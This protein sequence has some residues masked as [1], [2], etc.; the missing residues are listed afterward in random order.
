MDDIYKV[1]LHAPPHYFVPSAMYMVTG[2]ILHKQNL[3]RDNRCKKFFLRT[4]FEKAD[5]FR[6]HLQAWAVLHNHYHFISQSPEN[7]TT[8]AKLI[9]QVH[10]ITAIQF[11]RWANTPGRQVWQNYWDS[12]ITYEKSYL[13]RLRYVHENPVKLGLVENAADYPYCSY[14]WFFNQGDC[15]LKEQ[16]LKQPIDK[17]N[18][19]DDF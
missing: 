12:C 4:L 3:M 1:Y 2:A 19:F 14:R 8:L 18:V 17:I 11:N 15:H 16:V 13:A 6:W 10:S 9:Q 5:S 7:S